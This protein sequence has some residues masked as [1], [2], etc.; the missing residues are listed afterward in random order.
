ME[1]IDTSLLLLISRGD[2]LA[3]KELFRIYRDRLFNY[4]FKITK[5]RETAEEIAMDVFL[6]L[7]ECRTSVV[8]IKNFP[9]FV[10]LIARNKSID[11]LREAAKNPVLQELVWEEIQ[12]LSDERSDGKV[13]VNELQDKVNRAIKY[14]SP[15]RQTVFRLSREE[16]MS[17]D[18]I[19]KHLQLSKSTIKNH[20]LDSLKFIRTHL[21]AVILLY[22]FIGSFR[23]MYLCQVAILK[24]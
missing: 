11:F 13:I 6:K 16:N 15:Q 23:I 3:F 22:W 8:E 18:Q 5:S 4:I 10:F 20:M 17:Y 21:G 24:S 2:E 14:L 1:T 19:A 7:W 12:V 9:S